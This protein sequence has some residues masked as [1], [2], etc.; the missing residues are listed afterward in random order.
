MSSDGAEAPELELWSD[1][2]AGCSRY[3]CREAIDIKTKD[4]MK[5]DSDMFRCDVCLKLEIWSFMKLSV[6]RSGNF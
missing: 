2:T 1:Y 3:L 4:G 6:S 5:T